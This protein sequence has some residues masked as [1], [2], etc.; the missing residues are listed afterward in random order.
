MPTS[1]VLWFSLTG[2]AFFGF[3]YWVLHEIRAV[4]TRSIG[5]AF[6]TFVVDE[7]ETGEQ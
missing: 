3:V 7:E 6:G 1:L 5:E 2:V 4:D